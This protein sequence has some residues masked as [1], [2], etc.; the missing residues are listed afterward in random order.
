MSS[1]ADAAGLTYDSTDA[2]AAAG[3]PGTVARDAAARHHRAAESQ[4]AARGDVGA[5][6]PLLRLA[7][8]AGADDGSAARRVR[9]G[10]AAAAE[11]ARRGRP[12]RDQRRHRPGRLDAAVV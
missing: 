6:P 4:G 12:E 1:P 11:S 3:N 7:R 9:L 8:R 5:D 2:A 10:V